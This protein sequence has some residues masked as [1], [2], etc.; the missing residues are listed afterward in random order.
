MSRNL[1]KTERHMLP[2][3]ANATQNP[4]RIK[5]SEHTLVLRF[6]GWVVCFALQSCRP[7]LLTQAHERLQLTCGEWALSTDPA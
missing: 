7:K 1:C 5:G 6:H 3:K 2:M 4:I